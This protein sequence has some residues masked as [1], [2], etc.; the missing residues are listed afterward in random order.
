MNHITPGKIILTKSTCLVICQSVAS[1]HEFYLEMYEPDVYDE[2]QA[3]GT[4]KPKVNYDFYRNRFTTKFNI[5]F[6]SAF[7]PFLTL[8]LICPSLAVIF[9]YWLLIFSKIY[10]YLT[11]PVG[12]IFYLWQLWLTPFSGLRM[13]VAFSAQIEAWNKIT[14]KAVCYLLIIAKIHV[15]FP[16]SIKLYFYSIFNH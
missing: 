10:P 14:L 3:G 13:P 5:S 4:G 9:L 8:M 11:I 12:E 15:I 1:M 16:L 6:A 2:L 7:I